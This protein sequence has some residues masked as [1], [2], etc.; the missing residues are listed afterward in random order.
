MLG[1]GKGAGPQAAKGE[2][3]GTANENDTAGVET[4]HAQRSKHKEKTDGKVKH[5][6]LKSS[7]R[8]HG[9]AKFRQQTTQSLTSV[10]PSQIIHS[11]SLQTVRCRRACWLS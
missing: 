11:H 1:Q 4:R 8:S 5:S 6:D 9:Y 3:S 2:E 10:K 7:D